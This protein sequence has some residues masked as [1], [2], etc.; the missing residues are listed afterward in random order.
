MTGITLNFFRPVLWPKMWFI[1]VH[2]PRAL[3]KVVCSIVDWP[4]LYV[5]VGST[6]LIMFLVFYLFFWFVCTPF[7]STIEKRWMKSLT[8]TARLS[9]SLCSS[10][11]I[12]FLFL[13]TAFKCLRVWK[14]YVCSMDWSLHPCGVTYFYSCSYSLIRNV[15]YLNLIYSTLLLISVS[16]IYFFYYFFV[17]LY[18]KYACCGERIVESCGVFKY[19]LRIYNT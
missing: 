15:L 4:V 6:C 13:K 12:W 16:M 11:H 8:L 5:S 17:S 14:F 10:I 1:L 7:L 2:I 18:I 9:I 3:G 19:S